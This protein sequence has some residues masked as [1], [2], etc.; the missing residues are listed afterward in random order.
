M[1]HQRAGVGGGGGHAA[2]QRGH[3][4]KGLPFVRTAAPT[5]IIKHLGPLANKDEFAAAV[6]DPSTT[7]SA[8]TSSHVT[9]AVSTS[10]LHSTVSTS[11]NIP[12][13]ADVSK[14]DGPPSHYFHFRRHSA[15]L[16]YHQDL[17]TPSPPPS[18][19]PKIPSPLSSA[20]SSIAPAP[21]LPHSPTTSPR[22]SPTRD[23]HLGALREAA[24][25]VA[26]KVPTAAPLPSNLSTL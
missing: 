12:H 24:A 9:P 25:R 20:T 6:T 14:Q 2:S 7:T 18:A 19:V 22:R 17:P 26:A 5:I 16:N 3:S 11:P 1:T 23:V 21:Q 8:V 4:A 10:N 15:A 13:S